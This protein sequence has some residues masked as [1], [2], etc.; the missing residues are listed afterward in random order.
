MSNIT[1]CPPQAIQCLNL[2]QETRHG[3]PILEA[4]TSWTQGED[5]AL[6]DMIA[7]SL[8]VFASPDLVTNSS[9]PKTARQMDV[10]FHG[11]KKSKSYVRDYLDFLKNFSSTTNEPGSDAQANQTRIAGRSAKDAET[12]SDFPAHVHETLFNI[13]IKKYSQCCCARAGAP[14]GPLRQH[15]GSLKLRENIQIINDH[16][17]FDIVLS[18]SPR[19]CSVRGVEWQHL[20]FHIPR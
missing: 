2:A 12:P 11:V 18:R 3:Y 6:V 10:W 16:V 14:T 20:Q 4:L 17:V 9:G 15:E 19:D 1:Q 13:L 5:S 7:G 8:K